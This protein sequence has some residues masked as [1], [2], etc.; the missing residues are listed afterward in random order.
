MFARTRTALAAAVAA[1][2]L[3][4]A[5]AAGAAWGAAG[6]LPGSGDTSFNPAGDS[7][8]NRCVSPEG[9]DANELLGIS[10]QHVV[11]DFCDVVQAGEFYVFFNAVRMS[12]GEA[13][14][15]REWLRGH[16]HPRD[17]SSFTQ[18]RFTA[19]MDELGCLRARRG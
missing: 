4:V 18:C 17:L 8:D 19:G 16:A 3:A 14:P 10:E 2:S 6:G 5:V 7:E 15:G 12:G 9:V 1:L 13:R 11:T